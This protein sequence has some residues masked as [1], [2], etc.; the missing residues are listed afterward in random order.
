MSQEVSSWGQDFG[1]KPMTLCITLNQNLIVRPFTTL[2]TKVSVYKEALLKG[3]P[4]AFPSSV[5]H[6]TLK[7]A[8]LWG[9]QN[10]HR[11]KLGT[12]VL[13]KLLSSRPSQEAFPRGTFYYNFKPTWGY[14]LSL[15]YPKL[16]GIFFGLAHRVQKIITKGFW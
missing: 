1:M 9:G 4:C 14:L 8:T 6:D 11:P 16:L 12:Y 7:E 13:R 15:L 3:G 5:I 10:I 2:E